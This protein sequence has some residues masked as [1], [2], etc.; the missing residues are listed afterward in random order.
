M[1]QKKEQEVHEEKKPDF[2]QTPVQLPP[3]AEPAALGLI[4]LA[5]AALVLASTDLK[6]ASSTAR[7]LMIP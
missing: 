4:G 6:M 7:S 1:A 5:I 3:V 2:K